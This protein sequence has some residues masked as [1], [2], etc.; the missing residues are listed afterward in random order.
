M[1][2]E[3]VERG[4]RLETIRITLGEVHEC[5]HKE[6]ILLAMDTAAM[7]RCDKLIYFDLVVSLSHDTPE[8]TIKL[9][10]DKL[11][12]QMLI[13]CP[14]MESL[15]GE[16]KGVLRVFSSIHETQALSM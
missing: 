12:S 10:E 13:K 8:K 15:I 7:N 14:E 4:T 3:R 1:D 6:L 16:Y 11:S 9:W 5:I 2:N